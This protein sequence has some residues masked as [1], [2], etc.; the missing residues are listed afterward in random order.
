MNI[1][2]D[3]KGLEDPKDPDTCNVFALYKLFATAEEIEKMRE[4]YLGGNY[5]YGHAKLALFEKIWTTFE[6]MRKR[7]AELEANLPAVLEMIERNGEKAKAEAEKMMQRVRA[8][9]GLR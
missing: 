7:R 2:T 3:S 4:N 6:P 8:A 9:V 5:G 1:V